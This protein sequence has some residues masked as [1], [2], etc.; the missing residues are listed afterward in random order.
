MEARRLSSWQGSYALGEATSWARVI[1]VWLGF[2]TEGTPHPRAPGGF[3]GG[4]CYGR[5]NSPPADPVSLF[6]GLDRADNMGRHWHPFVL[7]KSGLA[8]L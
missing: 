1:G 6:I 4:A 2:A 3:W 5:L 8:C 7:I